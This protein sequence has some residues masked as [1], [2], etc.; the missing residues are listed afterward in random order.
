MKRLRTLILICI[1]CTLCTG[2]W[3]Q[4]F[5]SPGGSDA[6]SGSESA[7][8]ATV[9]KALRQVREL[10]RLQDP[11][12][13]NGIHILLKTGLYKL[14]EPIRIRPEDAG[15]KESPTFIEAAPDAKPVIS[16]GI[17]ITGWHKVISSINGLPAKANGKVWV[18]DIPFV[19]GS[20]FN[21]R[22]LWVNGLKATRAKTEISRILNWNKKDGTCWIPT[23][24]NSSNGAF[25]GTVATTWAAQPTI[26]AALVRFGVNANGGVFSKTLMYAVLILI[27]EQIPEF[28]TVKVTV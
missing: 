21:F 12:T 8:F 25:S 15:T 19:A 28:V 3:C 10:R 23:P 5:V 14:D 11:I 4:L 18:A 6:G 17:S 13:K 24:K 2:S 26:S 22:Q 9:S 16:G 1:A 20:K 7:P 27:S